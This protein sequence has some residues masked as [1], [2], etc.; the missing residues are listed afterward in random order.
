MSYSAGEHILLG[1]G[2]R[3]MLGH[4]VVPVLFKGQVGLLRAWHLFVI[5][6]QLNGD[7]RRMESTDM[8]DEGVGGPVVSGGAG[9]HLNLGWNWQT[10]KQSLTYRWNKDNNLIQMIIIHL[11]STN[12]LNINTAIICVTVCHAQQ[13]NKE[14]LVVLVKRYSAFKYKLSVV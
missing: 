10:Q 5:P 2:E 14:V 9:V 3:H 6:E 13:P 1:W 4:V 7:F 12:L 8:A 11:D